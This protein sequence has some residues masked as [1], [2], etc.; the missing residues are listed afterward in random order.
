MGTTGDYYSIL[1]IDRGASVHVV[2]TSYR[3]LM[4]KG[5]NHPDLGGD[6]KTAALINKAYA[7]LSDPALRSEYDA[8][9]S[10]LDHIARGVTMAPAEA[11]PDPSRA[12]LF[13]GQ[14]HQY[15][16]NDL[17]EV[18]CQNCGSALQS[19]DRSRMEPMGKRVVQRLGQCVDL[20]V[21]THWTQ[22]KGYAARTQDISPY[23]LRMIIPCELTLGQ[24]VHIVSRKLDAVGEVVYVAPG[25]SSWRRE[26]IAG[27]TFQT[28][29][30]DRRVGVFVTRQI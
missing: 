20:K 24:R 14:P 23:G 26:T 2:R 1:G 25:P 7:V 17:E 9:L 12:C 4:Q 16:A 27:V 13:C 3:R 10:V 11:P 5:G 15:G 29:R 30:Y 21:F 18:S 6:T 8:K 19:I 28:L 22:K